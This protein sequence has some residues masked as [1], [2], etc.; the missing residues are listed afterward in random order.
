MMVKLEGDFQTES[1]SYYIGNFENGSSEFF[2]GMVIPSEPGPL[3]GAVVFT[4][5]DSTGEEQEIR[6]EFTLNVMDMPPMDD[7]PDE[8]PPMDEGPGGIKGVLKSKWLW[9]SLALLGAG[10][11]GFKFYKKRKQKKEAEE[12]AFH[13]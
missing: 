3:E 10:F 13:E 2:E 5:E 4:Y 8:F 11:G 1:G 12:L 9:A 6:K 7:F